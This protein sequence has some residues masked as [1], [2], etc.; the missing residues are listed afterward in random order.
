[1]AVLGYW[2]LATI[3]TRKY[4]YKKKYR[5]TNTEIQDRKLVCLYGRVRILGIGDHPARTNPHLSSH[6]ASHFLSLF[7]F[8]IYFYL[9]FN[10]YLSSVTE[11]RIFPLFIIF[12]RIYCFSML[13]SLSWPFG[14]NKQISNHAVEVK[15]TREM[16][17]FVN[18]KSP[19]N[20]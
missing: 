8:F 1:M 11:L 14:T 6:W 13:K 15:C 2:L 10:P 5:N 4:K 18:C 12:F 16:Q 7:L 19:L 20:K 3:Q 17:L 9:L